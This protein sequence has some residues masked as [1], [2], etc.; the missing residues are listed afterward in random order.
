MVI[1]KIEIILRDQE[2]VNLQILVKYQNQGQFQN[3]LLRFPKMSLEVK[4]DPDLAEKIKVKDNGLI[5]K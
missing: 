1:S 4:F 5:P 2:C 3:L